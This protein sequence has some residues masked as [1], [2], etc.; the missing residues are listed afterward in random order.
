MF[1]F[2]NE[3]VDIKMILSYQKQEKMYFVLPSYF[4][5]LEN[6]ALEYRNHP[7]V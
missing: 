5:V 7:G 3:F 6:F 2:F 4:L 1:L